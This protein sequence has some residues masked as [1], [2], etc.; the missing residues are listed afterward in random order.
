MYILACIHM[1][2]GIIHIGYIGQ[3]V[4]R[5]VSVLSVCLCLASTD[6]GKRPLN[7]IG[8]DFRKKVSTYNPQDCIDVMS[9]RNG[10]KHSVS[11]LMEDV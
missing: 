2:M 6:L 7:P 1:C 8:L 9:K 10:R 4:C 5:C 3:V 11:Y